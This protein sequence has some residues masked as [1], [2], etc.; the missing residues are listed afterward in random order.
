MGDVHDRIKAA[1]KEIQCQMKEE[2][3]ILDKKR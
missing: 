1:A 2:L 3:M